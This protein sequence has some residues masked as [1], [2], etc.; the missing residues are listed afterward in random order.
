MKITIKRNTGF[1]GA[2][3]KVALKVDQQKVR[4]LKS[5]EEVECNI[6]KDSAEVSANQ[7]FF[8][9]KAVKV[10]AGEKVEIQTNPTSLLVSVGVLALL[11]ISFFLNNLVVS[12]IGLLGVIA[13]IPYLIKNYYVIKPVPSSGKQ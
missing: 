11:I 9:S 12:A 5:N 6:Q 7:W 3:S 13:V 2:A 1:M 4:A 8:G 10:S